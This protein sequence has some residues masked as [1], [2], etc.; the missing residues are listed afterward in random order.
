MTVMADLLYCLAPTDELSQG[1][2][3][4]CLIFVELSD[5]TDTALPADTHG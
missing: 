5:A 1:G 2:L 4:V 3:L